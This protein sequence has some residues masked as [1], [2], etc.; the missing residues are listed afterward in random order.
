[1]RRETLFAGVR[2]VPRRPVPSR[3]SCLQLSYLL[4]MMDSVD[5]PRGEPADSYF[6][7]D[8]VELAS[9]EVFVDCGAYD[10]DTSSRFWRR[11]TIASAPSW[12]SSQ[13]RRRSRNSGRSCGA[14]RP[15]VRDRIRVEQKRSRGCR[16]TAP[17]R[18]RRHPGSRL[19]ET[20]ALTVECVT[21]DA[22]LETLAPT[23]IKMDIEGAEEDA[24][25]GATQTIRAH[26]PILADLRLS[27]AVGSLSPPDAHREACVP[28]TA[29]SCAARA[30]RRP[31][32][33]RHPK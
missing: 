17:F 26:R 16:G 6:P 31:R 5:L 27:P 32:V 2:E 3:S 25:R 20:G 10:G 22:A 8:L 7:R 33:F 4:S 23:F 13:T 29:S 24:L 9:D 14:C 15:R 12:R 1:M 28:T 11:A 18:G 19:S 21:L 30:R